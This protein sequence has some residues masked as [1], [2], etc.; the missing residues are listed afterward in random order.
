[1][2]L[3]IKD[4]TLL[5]AEVGQCSTKVTSEKRKVVTRIKSGV[6]INVELFN[7]VLF[8]ISWDG[9]FFLPSFTYLFYNNLQDKLRKAFLIFT[10]CR[11]HWMRK[12]KYTFEFLSFVRRDEERKLRIDK[13]LKIPTS[14]RCLAFAKVR[15]KQID[16][17]LA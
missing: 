17:A 2:V 3:K 7:R 9:P 5:I 4:R 8:G 6:D 12:H 14:K 10:M 13:T 11:F 15:D 16:E 1:M